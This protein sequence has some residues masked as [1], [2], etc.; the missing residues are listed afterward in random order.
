LPYENNFSSNL[1]NHRFLLWLN[2]V[3]NFIEDVVNER[4]NH[5][6]FL[7]ILKSDFTKIDYQSLEKPAIKK[8]AIHLIEKMLFTK[9][10]NLLSLEKIIRIIKD[11]SEYLKLKD[12]TEE[13]FE[14]NLLATNIIVDLLA[15]ISQRTI[16]L[17]AKIDHKIL[18]DLAELGKVLIEIVELFANEPALDIAAKQEEQE[19]IND[20]LNVIQ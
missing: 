3:I 8:K 9:D 17:K 4:F 7:A 1:A 20:F 10:C 15:K 2:L 14:D 11:G 5:V 18:F 12:C 16:K 13:D 6:V 19:A